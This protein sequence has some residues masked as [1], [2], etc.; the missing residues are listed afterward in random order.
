MTD[1]RIPTLSNGK[2]TNA[3]Y[4]F[5]HLPGAKMGIVTNLIHKGLKIHVNAL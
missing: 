4:L 5:I 1:L 2:S 3:T